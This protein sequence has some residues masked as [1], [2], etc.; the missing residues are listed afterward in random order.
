MA[1]KRGRPPVKPALA[2]HRHQ[3]GVLVAG[4]TKDA[5]AASAKVSGRSLSREA[6]HLIERALAYDYAMSLMR[7][8]LETMDQDGVD[9]ELRRRG[10]T[11][12]PHPVTGKMLWAEPGYPGIKQGGFLQWD[13]GEQSAAAR[14]AA[15]IS[16]KEIERRNQATLEKAENLPRLDISETLEILDRLDMDESEIQESAASKKDDAA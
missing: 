15:G 5:I 4:P 14:G 11:G 10:Y 1:D 16:E 7:T 3:I 2:G 12:I 8:T 6:E 9:A 13:E